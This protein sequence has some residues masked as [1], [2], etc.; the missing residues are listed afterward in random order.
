[1]KLGYKG[2]LCISQCE[3]FKMNDH[4]DTNLTLCNE[5]FYWEQPSW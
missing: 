1:M 2:Q 3:S 5:L 4:T